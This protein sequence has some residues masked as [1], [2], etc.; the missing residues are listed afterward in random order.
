M[1]EINRDF[2]CELLEKPDVHV[3]Y[4]KSNQSKKTA[5]IKQLIAS[6]KSYLLDKYPGAQFDY[7][8]IKC[9]LINVILNDHVVTLDILK[10]SERK[11]I[12]TI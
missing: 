4:K 9:N 10:R 1:I 8:N 7:N 2:I 12:I 11:Y 5:I 6:L 3:K